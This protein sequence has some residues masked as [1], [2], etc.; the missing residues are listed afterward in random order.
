MPHE[1]KH[2]LHPAPRCGYQMGQPAPAQ[3][4]T[5]GQPA[6]CDSRGQETQC[7][8]PWIHSVGGG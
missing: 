5:T 7:G 4:T 1:E 6:L 3:G 8:H 2:L